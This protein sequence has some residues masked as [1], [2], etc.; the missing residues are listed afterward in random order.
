MF[1]LTLIGVEIYCFH[2]FLTHGLFIKYSY[3]LD[4]LLSFPPYLLVF[5]LLTAGVSLSLLAIV[6]GFVNRRLWTRRF[7]LFFLVWAML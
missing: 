1:L 5:L 3:T 7:A 6:Y 4:S 2:S